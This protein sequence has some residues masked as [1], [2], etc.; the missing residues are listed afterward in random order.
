MV[1][2]PKLRVVIIDELSML[3]DQDFLLSMARVGNRSQDPNYPRSY[4][5][6]VVIGIG[7]SR[8]LDPVNATSTLFDPGSPDSKLPEDIWDVRVR[9]T[10]VVRHSGGILSLATAIR[11]HGVAGRPAIDIDGEWEDNNVVVKTPQDWVDHWLQRLAIQRMHPQEHDVQCLA[12]RNK[13]VA[14]L[15]AMARDELYGPG[16]APFQEAERILSMDSILDPVE[17]TVLCGSATEIVVLSSRLERTEMWGGVLNGYSIVG[18]MPHVRDESGMARGIEFRSIDPADRDAYAEA[19][20]NAKEPAVLREKQ[21]KDATKRGARWS[22]EQE[23][24]RKE[25]WREYYHVV[26]HFSPTEP[27][28]CMTVDK[29]QGSTYEEIFVD[30]IDIDTCKDKETQNRLTYVAVSRASERLVIRL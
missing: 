1:T 16:A 11:E 15:N 19:I 25:A 14:K 10:E 6:V 4:P 26:E 30:Q 20:K 22:K 3:S 24:L 2:P 27:A 21:K 12:F 13:T 29:S 7:D 8:Q 9:L 23:E 5:Q 28:Y 17:G 18:F